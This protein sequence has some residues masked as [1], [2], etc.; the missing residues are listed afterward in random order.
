MTS[1]LAGATSFLSPCVLPL[2]PGYVAYVTGK[3]V[4][5]DTPEQLESRRAVLWLSLLFV[6]GFSTVFIAFG[7]SATALGQ[8]LLSIRYEANIAAGVAVMVFGLLMLGIVRWGWLQRDLRLHPR[9][10][11]AGPVPAYLL[12]LAFAFGWTPCIGPILG[13]ILTT[14]AASATLAQG[15][16]LLTAYSL[17]LGVPFVVVAV[18]TNGLTGKLR[19]YARLGR[20]L[21]TVAGAA[22]VI[23]GLAMATGQLTNFSYWLLGVFP[24]LAQI[25]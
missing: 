14:S 20:V 18:S 23:M 5:P 17:G 16:T 21:Q 12:G 19:R 9:L 2:V 25:G 3:S 10:S 15:V 22:M 4:D 8:F 13:A 1:L 7:A 24:V 6:L 11:T